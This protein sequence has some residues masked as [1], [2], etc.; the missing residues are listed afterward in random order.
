[1]IESSTYRYTR[2]NMLVEPQFQFSGGGE[3]VRYSIHLGFAILDD[4]PAN[5]TKFTYD[6][7]TLGMGLTFTL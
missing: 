1:V 6:W 4:I 7:M 5:A 2:T 3:K